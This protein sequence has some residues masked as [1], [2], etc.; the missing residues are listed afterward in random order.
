MDGALEV[1]SILYISCLCALKYQLFEQAIF[2]SHNVCPTK[3]QLMCAIRIPT[4]E[5][6]F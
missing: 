2:M 4:I 3:Q 1:E 6:Q 5:K